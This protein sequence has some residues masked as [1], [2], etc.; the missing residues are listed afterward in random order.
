M[1]R[2]RIHHAPLSVMIDFEQSFFCYLTLK[3][4]LGAK[5][6]FKRIWP[7]INIRMCLFHLGQSVLRFVQVR[8]LY[9]LKV[10]C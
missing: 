2:T 8:I 6:A 10:V 9:D 1:L 5:N 3:I 4:F 7:N